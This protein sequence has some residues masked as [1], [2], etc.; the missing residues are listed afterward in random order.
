[1]IKRY[2]ELHPS[3]Y[4]ENGGYVSYTREVARLYLLPGDNRADK[5]IKSKGF[6]Q[7][8]TF[9]AWAELIDRFQPG[10]ILDVGSNHG[11]MVL[12][13]NVRQDVKV[14]LYEP[15]DDLAKTLEKSI[16]SHVRADNFKVVR[17]AVS[18]RNGTSTFN[19]DKK[20][21]GT[22]SLDYQAPDRN[23]K[24]VGSQ[25]Y[26]VVEVKTVTL[27]SIIADAT[28][29]GNCG[30]IA[31]KIDVEGHEPSVFRGGRSQLRE[32]QFFCLFEYSPEQIGRAG[33]NGPAML[34][35]LAG[36]GQIY[37][38][39]GYSGMKAVSNVTDIGQ[40]NC[41]LIVSNIKFPDDIIVV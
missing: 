4:V 40:K 38:I 26:D 23:Y 25:T 16:S 27:D 8:R 19:I 35:G 14:Y 5:I 13:L 29:S 17:A 20:W 9:A 21:S 7:P 31:I 12:P 28:R 10:M 39:E 22:S 30:P 11:E 32:K 24:G 36:L 6:T 3:V 34:E 37:T 2:T 33:E 18:D 15:N 1:M 41:D